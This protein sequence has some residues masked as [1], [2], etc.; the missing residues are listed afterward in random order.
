M[1]LVDWLT[2]SASNYSEAHPKWTK[3]NRTLFEG[4]I[5]Q[6]KK[7]DASLVKK[8]IKKFSETDKTKKQTNAILTALEIF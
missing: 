4:A 2:Q 5:K 7:F 6:L 1:S 3:E 8:A